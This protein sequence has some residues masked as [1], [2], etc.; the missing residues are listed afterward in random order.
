M[1]I[2]LYNVYHC[3]NVYCF[4]IGNIEKKNH[5]IKFFSQYCMIVIS[6]FLL[7]S[8]YIIPLLTSLTAQVYFPPWEPQ[9]P[10]ACSP[11]ALTLSTWTTGTNSA[12]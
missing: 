12:S 5:F 7:T 6:I 4:H 11:A 1:G 2:F 9:N 8:W 10:D 3:S